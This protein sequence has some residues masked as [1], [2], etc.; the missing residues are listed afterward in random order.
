MLCS[1]VIAI[2]LFPIEFSLIGSIGTA[3]TCSLILYLVAIHAKEK[4]FISEKNMELQQQIND[5]IAKIKHKDILAM[6]E[7]ELYEHCRNCGLSEED[8]KI[9]YLIVIERLK[10][11]QLY[12]TIRYSESQTKRKRKQILNKIKE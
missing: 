11:R 2:W 1:G 12:K 10:G 6:N 5:L 8:C 9:A 7:D 4:R 3:L